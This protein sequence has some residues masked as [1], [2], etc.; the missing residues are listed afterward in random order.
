MTTVKK[1]FKVEI[2]SETVFFRTEDEAQDHAFIWAVCKNKMYKIT[3]IYA[4]V[5][6]EAN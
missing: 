1:A 5:L 4:T 6:E 3:P 2:D